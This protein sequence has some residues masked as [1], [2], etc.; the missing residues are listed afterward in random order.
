MRFL[1]VAERELRAAARQKRTYRV[2]WITAVAF[3]GLQVWMTWAFDGFSTRGAG[4]TIFKGLSLVTFFYCVI[5][6]ATHTA[7]CLSWEKREGTL[8]LLFLTN[9]SSAEIVA[10]KLC[11]SVLAAVYGLFA[12][13]PLLALP[14]LLG[15]V[16]FGY[17]WR[18]ILALLNALF[19][20]AAVGFAASVVSVRQFRAIALASG[21]SLYFCFGLMGLAES[22]R[23][24]SC[25]NRWRRHWKTRWRRPGFH[26][27]RLRPIVTPKRCGSGT[28]APLW[29]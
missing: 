2:R 3:F 1:S 15:G 7:D 18:T 10:G 9:L 13:F 22:L 26:S 25:P 16:S 17:F 27:S 29:S 24:F 14:L 6:G 19:F 23:A 5:V 21:L 20:S 8:G 11:S 28:A 12:V 4:P